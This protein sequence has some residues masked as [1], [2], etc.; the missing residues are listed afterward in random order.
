VINHAP[1]LWNRAL[2]TIPPPTA[3]RRSISKGPVINLIE[4]QRL[5]R[6]K[7]IDFDND[8]WA[9]TPKCRKDITEHY[10]WEYAQIA[11]MICA[12]KPGKGPKGDYKKSEWCTVDGGEMYPCDVYQL[13]FDEVRGERNSS[14]NLVIYLKFSL[15]TDGEVVLV[16]VSCHL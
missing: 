6:N 5:I 13:P 9:A 4:L 3:T 12:L 15:S 10:S 8:L 2:G 11:R 1:T 7:T 14:S 16:L